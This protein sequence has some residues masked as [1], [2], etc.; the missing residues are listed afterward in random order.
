MSE[1]SAR[2]LAQ[3]SI[4]AE[5]RK[6]SAHMRGKAKRLYMRA[7]RKVAAAAQSNSKG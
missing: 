2:A 7:C 3:E 4:M 5:A 6:V 1:Q